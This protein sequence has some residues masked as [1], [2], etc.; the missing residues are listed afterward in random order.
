[1]S[2]QN[3]Y[4]VLLATVIPMLG[5]LWNWPVVWV[6]VGVLLLESIL[7]EPTK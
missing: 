6:R 5:E 7:L 3:R 4:G 1:L 2:K